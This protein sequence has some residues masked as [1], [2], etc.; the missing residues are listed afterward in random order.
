MTSFGADDKKKT[1]EVHG[2]Q[3][4][5]FGQ[6]INHRPCTLSSMSGIPMNGRRH[7]G[8]PNAILCR[9]AFILIL[10]FGE[11]EPPGG[12]SAPN[13]GVNFTFR[14]VTERNF[15]RAVRVS[16]WNHP[17]RKS[18]FYSFKFSFKNY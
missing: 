17:V 15:F 12:S 14:S 9:F 2:E 13:N 4:F 16:C 3:T 1:A 18:K 10:I 5:F 8:A 11:R 7:I 6:F